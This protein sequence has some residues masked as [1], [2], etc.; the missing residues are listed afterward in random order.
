MATPSSTGL[1]RWLPAASWLP[2]Y[3]RG[4][5]PSDLV[6]G[7]V[8]A[9]M[10]VPQAMAYA[11]LAGLP[12]QVGLYASIVPVALYAIFG[13]STSLAVGPVA[14]VSLLV[15]TGVSELA[16][17]GTE[18]FV[19]YALT[20]ALMVGLLQA[21]MGLARMGFLVNF[22]SHAVLAGFTSAA[23]LV[24]AGSQL[25]HLFGLEIGRPEG[26]LETVQAVVER[27]GQVNPTTVLLTLT[28]LSIL[29]FFRSRLGPLLVRAGASESWAA[30]LAKTGPFV[31][32]G[33]TAAL[34][35]AMSLDER[36]SVAVV[37]VIPQGLPAVGRP[38]L[39]AAALRVLLPTAVAICF[40]GFLESF[41]IARVL[42]AKR[43]ERV[44]ANQELLALGVAN[45]G[46]AFTGGYPVTG[47]FSRSMV[48]FTAGARS[49]LAALVTAALVAV[50][51]IWMTP[52][53]HHL[54]KAALAAIIVVAVAQLVDWRAAVRAW[55]YSR[56]DGAA[57]TTTFAAVLVLGVEAGIVIGAVVAVALHV[58][59]TTQPHMAV[60]GRVAGSEHYRNVLRHQVET[61]PE[62]LLVRVD[63]SLYFAN[64]RNLEDEVLRAV[65]ER[66]RLRDFVLIASAVNFIDGSALETLE[67]LR[68]E[69][70]S[71]G[72]TFHLAEVKGPVM[73]RLQRVSFVESMTPGRIFL[74]TQEAVDTLVAKQRPGSLRAQGGTS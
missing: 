10:L 59:R 66:P 6:A 31:A 14:I 41:A 22:L 68:V 52:A 54:P 72:V 37:G 32:V 2:S 70:D 7:L 38:P 15:A 18:A 33:V 74:S 58:W 67:T 60:V 39:D 45:L 12:A 62:L 35:A 64:A 46:A 9:I 71:A 24:I 49:G 3:R 21:A 23:A 19:G 44:R 56:A 65:A 51:V 34:T 43:R 16:E 30:P 63:E 20:L 57:F 28:A 47:G 17:P 55:K 69:L 5:L 27:L 29:L 25:R 26:F 42:A 36:A 40:I 8:V 11:L 13:T 48:N 1:A 53:F 61:W 4:D 73:D 50:A